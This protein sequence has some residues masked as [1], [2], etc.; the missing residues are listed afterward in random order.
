MEADDDVT[1]FVS[2]FLTG[3]GPCRFAVHG[4][5]AALARFFSYLAG[6]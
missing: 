3:V 4:L 6:G 1:G 5:S 2:I